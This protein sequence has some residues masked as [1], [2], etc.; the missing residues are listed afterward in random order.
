MKERNVEVPQL[1][2]EKLLWAF[3]R[4]LGLLVLSSVLGAVLVL[5]ATM[6]LG[7]TTYQASVMFY[8]NNTASTGENAKSISNGDLTTSRGLVDSYIAILNT[9]ETL[10]QILEESGAKCTAEELAVKMKTETVKDTELFRVVITGFD[11][12]EAEKIAE[13]AARVLPERISQIITGASAKVADR[14][15]VESCPPD[16]GNCA[17]LGFL[18]GLMLAA[19]RVLLEAYLDTTIRRKEDAEEASSLPVL[20]VLSGGSAKSVSDPI[21]QLRAKVRFLLSGKAEC[22]VLGITGIGEEKSRTAVEVACALASEEK[23]VLL[24][25]CDPEQPSIHQMF[26]VRKVPGVSDCLAGRE[27][28]ENVVR[29]CENPHVHVIPAGTD[30]DE[31]GVF[32]EMETMAQLL[33]TLS[34]EYNYILLALPPV[35]QGDVLELAGMVDGFLLTVCRDSCSRA[36]LKD[37]AE[38]L[39][40][41][42]ANILGLVYHCG[43]IPSRY[44]G[45]YARKRQERDGKEK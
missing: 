13:A 22:P 23:P 30:R 26:G 35:E 34:R 10:Q 19:G 6:L 37:A 29:S 8:V 31:N 39:R 36:A 16:Y 12:G 20:A 24:M 9:G 45:K 21:R 15:A 3:W 5:G 43:P 38:Q 42:G 11:A 40:F 27:T 1:N 25:D 17:L 7:K 33:E 14:A 2:L 18:M 41:V 28:L 32:P 4:R 44:T